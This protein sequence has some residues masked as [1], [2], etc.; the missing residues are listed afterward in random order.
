[1][2]KQLD[3]LSPACSEGHAHE[4]PTPSS[5]RDGD[6][7]HRQHGLGPIVGGNGGLR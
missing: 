1:M 7:T 2:G 4:P 5:E 6:R 3:F